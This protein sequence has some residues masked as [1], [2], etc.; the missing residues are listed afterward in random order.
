[1]W[2]CETCGERMADQFVTCRR[3]S[4]PKPG[5]T[6]TSQGSAQRAQQWRLAYRKFRGTLATWDQLFTE[7][8]QFATSQGPERVLS[9]SHSSDHSDGVVTVWYWTTSAAE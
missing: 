2:T 1:M 5:A 8:A 9:I 4:S 3:C 6:S 7:A